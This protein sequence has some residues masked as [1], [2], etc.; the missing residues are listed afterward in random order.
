MKYS[1]EKN[2]AGKYA[3]KKEG[4]KRASKVFDTEIEEETSRRNCIC[5]LNKIYKTVGPNYGPTV[6][7]RVDKVDTLAE[8]RKS[9]HRKVPD[10]FKIL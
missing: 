7:Q 5:K 3:V 8:F 1:I 10:F 6:F 4:A 2:K 9:P